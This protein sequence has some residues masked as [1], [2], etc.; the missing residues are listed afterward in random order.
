MKTV[1][2]ALD[3]V[4]GA[5]ARREAARGRRR[6]PSSITA[7]ADD[8][9]RDQRAMSCQ[10][11]QALGGGGDLGRRLA[12]DAAGG[13]VLDLGE[14]QAAAAPASAP[15]VSASGR[16]RQ[17]SASMTLPWNSSQSSTRTSAG[18][19]TQIGDE[20]AVIARQRMHRRA[21]GRRRSAGR[22]RGRRDRRR[23]RRR[24]SSGTDSRS[25]RALRRGDGRGA[26]RRRGR[27]IRSVGRSGPWRRRASTAARTCVALVVGERDQAALGQVAVRAEGLL[28][29]VLGDELVEA[30][31]HAAMRVLDVDVERARDP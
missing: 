31:D 9:Q 3:A 28:G 4:A 5:E 23:A 10:R 1:E 8:E 16:L 19:P 13:D 30:R 25:R 6:A 2:E 11:L 17:S 22:R 26:P 24:G 7:S 15:A 14:D 27:R 12:E 29:D 18:T 21:V 20:G